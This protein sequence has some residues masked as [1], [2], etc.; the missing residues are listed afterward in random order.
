MQFEADNLAEA[1]AALEE[2]LKQWPNSGEAYQAREILSE[3]REE[4]LT[5][6]SERSFADDEPCQLHV[7]TRNV[8]DLTYKAYKIDLLEYFRKKHTV[9]GVEQLAFDI[10][11]PG[12]TWTETDAKSDRYRLHERDV[13]LPAKGLGAFIVIAEGKKQQATGLAIRS[14]LQ[15]VTKQGPR[16]MLVFAQDSRTGKPLPGAQVLMSNGSSIVGEGQTGK[17]GVYQHK[18]D[19]NPGRLRVFA[20]KGESYAYSSAAPL[21]SVS[22]GYSAKAYLFTDRPVYRP[23]DTVQFK[24]ILR[25]VSAGLYQASGGK[26]VEVEVRD[27]HGI[28]LMRRELETNEFGSFT[29]KLRV[30]AEAPVGTYTLSCKHRGNHYSQTFEVEAYVKPELL[31]DVATSGS[32]LTGEDLEATVEARFAFGGAVKNAPVRYWVY[33]KGY[34]FDATRYKSF[35]WFF[36]GQKD[37]SRSSG[38]GQLVTSGEA[39]TDADGNARLTVPTEARGNHVM[40]IVCEVQGPNRRWASGGASV[41]V[42]EQELFVVVKADRKVYRP[43]DGVRVTAIGVDAAHRPHPI[44]GEVVIRKRRM[45]E[46]SMRSDPVRRIPL[47]LGADGRAETEVKIDEPGEYVV[48]FVAKDRRGTVVEG[49]AQVMVAGET[50]DLATEARLLFER[51]VYTRGEE[52]T[53]LINAPE[54]NVYALLT[55]EGEGV[56]SYRVLQLRARSQTIPV[57]MRDEWSPNVFAHVAIATRKKLFT[58]SDE[59]AV[60]KFLKVEVTADQAEALP[61]GKVKFTVKTTDHADKPVAAEVGLVVVDE[62]VYAIR[63]DLTPAMQPFFYDQKRLLSVGTDS[64][65][66][67]THEGITENRSAELLAELERREWEK[68]EAEESKKMGDSLRAR[69]KAAESARARPARSPMPME[70]AE[71][72]MVEMEA[73]LDEA[74]GE[75]MASGGFGG[76]RSAGKAMMSFDEEEADSG[77]A[78]A[79]LRQRF[80]DTAYWNPFVLTG[81]TGTATVEVTLPDNLTT[82]RA[83]ARGATKDTLVGSAEG[84]VVARQDIIVR[85]GLPRFCAE[86]DAFT[87]GAIMQNQAKVAVKSATLK[88]G[89]PSMAPDAFEAQVALPAGELVRREEKVRANQHGTSLI[90][91]DLLTKQGSDAV[92]RPLRI[93]PFGEKVREA[94]SGLLASR[95]ASFAFEVHEDAVEGTAKLKLRLTPTP[96]A[97]VTDA[98][99]YLDTYPYGCVEQTVNRFAPIV[100]AATALRK[101]G[102]PEFER[103]ARLSDHVELGVQRLIHMQR[104]DG[105]WGWWAESASRPET[106]ALALEGL[107]LAASGGFFVDSN[108]LNRGRNAA[109]NLLRGATPDQRA[110]L[111]RALA[112]SGNVNDAELSRGLREADRMSTIG[113]A[114]LAIACLT[115][116]REPKATPLLAQLRQAVQ[117]VESPGGPRPEAYWRGGERGWFH[118][119]IEATARAAQAL[120]LQDA[121]EPLADAAIRWILSRQ[122]GGHWRSTKDT[123]A[124]VAALAAWMTERGGGGLVDT[125]VIVLLDGEE[126]ARTRIRR[127]AVLADDLR[128]LTLEGIKP[129]KHQLVLRRGGDAEIPFSVIATHVR[130]R[131]QVEAKGNQVHV[132]RKIVRWIP[133]VPE[134]DDQGRPTTP[135]YTVLEPKARPDWRAEEA[136][137]EVASGELVVVRLAVTVD[138]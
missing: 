1:I 58:A 114:S 119:N 86:G 117:H 50:R 69:Q 7:T 12:A 133:E 85:L 104:G 70:S 106:T 6:V 49:G 40:S 19:H 138:E 25:T 137:S 36:Q 4:T 52:A 123:G 136:L 75:G 126:K 135:G 22:F 67:W 41:F 82:W 105:G 94:R 80:A 91:A 27:S 63:P 59:V 18:F 109:R 2:L 113:V 107:E 33:R 112:R 110:V 51:E 121:K 95:E 115:T 101:A 77:P 93:V 111:L 9:V 100:A 3:M 99:L 103:V 56:L 118:S 44:E 11:A 55:F 89:L 16:Q 5:L 84:R 26:K 71:A 122:A 79:R 72:P 62:T 24:G 64:S 45:I 38:S 47:V 15:I 102:S 120:I 46:G 97:A 90:R 76:R 68:R 31:I 73:A 28:A 54:P 10:V 30:G 108:V 92:E 78:A 128:A 37:K 17:D 74:V 65:W 87:I 13:T 57:R 98:L 48:A 130:R 42:T 23:G 88:L 61:G 14:N 129:G 83:T 34:A 132:E 35:A 29:G 81:R 127:G 60:L 20:H 66:G 124:C 125:D 39:T 116:R 96:D 134:T 53:L 32:L 131:E 21:R 8:F 43:G